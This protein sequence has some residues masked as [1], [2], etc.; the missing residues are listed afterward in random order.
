VATLLFP[1]VL[2]ALVI[3]A[4]IPVLVF[5]VEVVVAV[6]SNLL[7]LP[8]TPRGSNRSRVAVLIPAH[9]ES[10]GIV[11]TIENVMTQLRAGD[12]LLV[13]ADNCTDDTSTV[14]TSLGVEV[15]ERND[16]LRIGKGYAL[17]WGVKHLSADPP[18]IVV[19][20]DADCCFSEGSI[21]H[22]AAACH[23]N[24]R[25]AQALNLMKAPA[26]LPDS[27]QFAEFAWRVKNWVRPLGLK[28]LHLPCHLTGT[29]MAFPWEII[30]SA[31]LASGEIVEDLK[32]GL[33]LAKAGYSPVFCPG[34]GVVSYFPS[35]IAGAKT[36]RERWEQGHLNIIVTL[37][38]RMIWDAI[39][40]ANIGLFA[41]ALDAT[42][43]PIVLL[44]FLEATLLL[45][46]GMALAWGLSGSSFYIALA[47][48]S[49]LA[50]AI[51]LC[52]RN[53]GRDVLPLGK[54]RPLQNLLIGKLDLYRRIISRD[55]T[56]QWVR[57]DRA[58]T[59]PPEKLIS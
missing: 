29:G 22:L 53:F 37:V 17:D 20:L 26:D 56:S 59:P 13:V 50:I 43:P 34:A 57:T 58:K 3:L 6:N 5:F 16:R 40:S 41:L 44:A 12:R 42:V 52:W 46:S 27:F 2:L 15:I 8:G 14:A 23:V 48:V 55:R 21:D 4:A 35:S 45:L 7:R 18:E 31:H 1:S 49:A 11:P 10:V 32:L 19:I 9:N 39:I 30:Q 36:Q 33:E 51:L 54:I 47:S 24:G 25:P 28:K 38:P